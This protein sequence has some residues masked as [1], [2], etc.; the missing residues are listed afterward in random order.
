MPTQMKSN[1]AALN[2]VE[3]FCEMRRVVAAGVIIVEVD[4]ACAAVSVRITQTGLT[5]KAVANVIVQVDEALL[6]VVTLPAKSVPTTEGD[7][8]QELETTVG[9]VPVEFTLLRKVELPFTSSNVIGAA[10]LM[11][12]GPLI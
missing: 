1:T 7:V 6:P 2:C 11:P 10:V 5:E 4:T 12:N 3:E 8:P 9:A